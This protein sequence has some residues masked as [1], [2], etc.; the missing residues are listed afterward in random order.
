MDPSQN[1]NHFSK[2]IKQTDQQQ[3]HPHY[4]IST[5]TIIKTTITI[6]RFATEEANKNQ[7]IKVQIQKTR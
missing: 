4:P 3:H 2:P 5:A 6:G 1:R 7:I